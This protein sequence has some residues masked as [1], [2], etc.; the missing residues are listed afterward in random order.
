M[1]NIKS[2][3]KRVRVTFA[4]TARNKSYSSALKTSIKKAKV[5]LDGESNGDNKVVLNAISAIDRAVS[6]G[7]IHKNNAARKKSNL[8]RKLSK[9]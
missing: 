6:K 7:I 8:A 9:I 3:K 4:K 1:P 5:F 2:A